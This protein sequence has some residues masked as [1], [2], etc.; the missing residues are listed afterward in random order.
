MDTVLVKTPSIKC[1]QQTIK[2]NSIH[3]LW[4][5]YEQKVGAGFFLWISGAESTLFY[6]RSLECNN[7]YLKPINATIHLHT[8]SQKTYSLRFFSDFRKTAEQLRL[9]RYCAFCQF[10]F[11]E[12][13]QIIPEL[14]EEISLY[15]RWLFL[16]Q[17]VL[18]TYLL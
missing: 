8:E 3:L 9:N 11:T 6:D 4:N 17:F 2:K 16:L 14:R 1:T 5:M 13:H 10:L 7:W 18:P 12:Q 15:I